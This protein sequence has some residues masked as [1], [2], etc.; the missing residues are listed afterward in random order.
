MTISKKKKIRLREM[1]VK[2]AN[3]SLCTFRVSAIAFN[4]KGE[5]IGTSY[6]KFRMAG[7]GK[8]IHAEESLI[9]RYSS[10]IKTI[11]ICRIG[12]SGDILPIDPCPKCQKLAE[13]YGIKIISIS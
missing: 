7:K 1:L 3:Q 9:K 11:F 8:G 2:K 5:A 4:K 6:C 12:R 10:N 13:K